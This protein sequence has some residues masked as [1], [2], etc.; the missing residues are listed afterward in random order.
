MDEV[1]QN[2]QARRLAEPE[3]PRGLWQIQRQPWHLRVGAKDQSN[4]LYARRFA[5]YT[6]SCS[7]PALASMR[8]RRWV[9]NRMLRFEVLSDGHLVPP[10]Q[11]PAAEEHA[12][13]VPSVQKMMEDGAGGRA[14]KR[15]PTT[16]RTPP[17]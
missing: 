6:T 17:R 12:S 10:R 16:S 1:T 15:D 8:W 7:A 4:Q 13:A 5:V 14:T 9:L 11:A 2:R 3:E